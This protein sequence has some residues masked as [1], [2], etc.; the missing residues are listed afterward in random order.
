MDTQ[1]RHRPRLSR[2]QAL[3]PRGAGAVDLGR[4]RL[5]K[6]DE[7]QAVAGVRRRE[8]IVRGHR[9]HA[10]ARRDRDEHGRLGA[11]CEQGRDAGE[12]GVVL[13]EHAAQ[14]RAPGEVHGQRA[15]DAVQRLRR[16][17]GGRHGEQRV[18]QRATASGAARGLG[19]AGGT[20]VD[21]DDERLRM[22]GGGSQD[23]A[24]VTG[25][26]IDRDPGVP[27]GELFE[28]ADVELEQAPALD[29]AQHAPSFPGA[30]HEV[31]KIVQRANRSVL[32][33]SYF[34]GAA[35]MLVLAALLAAAS[36]ITAGRAATLSSFALGGFAGV[37]RG[38]ELSLAPAN[39]NCGWV[40]RLG[41][42]PP[43]RSGRGPVLRRGRGRLGAMA[44]HKWTRPPLR[45]AGVCT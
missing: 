13:A 10:V 6:L 15:G 36:L 21:A 7:A 42:R 1:T 26:E 9:R 19:H 8:H 43:C 40:G 12:H 20:G 33:W 45:K 27:G 29:D 11:G 22:G 3:G 32:S 4:R 5:A 17:L 25:A 18:G 31:V 30:S 14:Q 44:V 37:D 41:C 16:V 34:E 2:P 24:A 38:A 23:A 35:T 39:V 28:S